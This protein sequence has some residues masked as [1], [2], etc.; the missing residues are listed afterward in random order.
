MNGTL[1]CGK[2]EHT[3][4]AVCGGV[5]TIT[6]KYGA[7]IGN[8]WPTYNGSSTWRTTPNGGPYQVNIETM[9][10]NGD[11]FY[12]PKTGKGSETAYYYVEVLPR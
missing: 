11:D 10:L 3:H 12:G 9:P 1:R 8:Q 4:D 7:Y 6:A 2:E 5:L